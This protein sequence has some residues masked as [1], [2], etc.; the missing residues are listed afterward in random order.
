MDPWSVHRPSLSKR[1]LVNGDLKK[2]FKS[3]L[4]LYILVGIIGT[5]IFISKHFMSLTVEPIS[6]FSLLIYISS[7]SIDYNRLVQ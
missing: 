2:I 5:S 4:V 6:P 7:P 3:N 1:F